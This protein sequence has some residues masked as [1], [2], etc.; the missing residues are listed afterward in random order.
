MQGY[1]ALV[2]NPHYPA[3]FD[4]DVPTSTWPLFMRLKEHHCVSPQ[5]PVPAGGPEDDTLDDGIR[6]AWFPP[7]NLTTHRVCRLRLQIRHDP[8]F[9]FL[10]RV[11]RSLHIAIV[12][13]C[14]ERS[15]KRLSKVIP[16]R[17]MKI[18]VSHA[19]HVAS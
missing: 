6:N 2:T 9:A 17:T 5:E 14:R 16:T 19:K 3:H 12:A 10:V 18:L 11:A 1:L 4:T 13:R 15:T 7:I 8:N